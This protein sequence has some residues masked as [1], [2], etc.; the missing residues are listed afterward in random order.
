V[1]D[2]P[3]SSSPTSPSSTLTRSSESGSALVTEQGKTTIADTVVA[4]IAGIAAGE[5]SG[6]HS[7]GGGAA[8][9]VGALRERIPGGRTNHSQGVSVEVGERQ[10]AVDVQLVASTASRSPT[11][12]RASGATS[13]P[14][15][16]G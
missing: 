3:S 11:W 14:R 16:S 13:S 9:A 1:S 8:R 7:L 10:A 15:S 4:K 12:P 5:V 2:H 6:V